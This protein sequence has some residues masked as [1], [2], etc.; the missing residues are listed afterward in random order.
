M[1]DGMLW[2]PREPL[3][4]ASGS[5]TRREMLA[6]A[7]IPVEVVR[8]EVDERALE[9]SLEGEVAS[10]EKVARTLAAA[11]AL[12][13]SALH[14]DRLVLAADQTLDCDGRSFHK[15][16]DLAEAAEQ[17]LRLAGRSHRL[18]AAFALAHRGEVVAEGVERANLAM[19]AFDRAFV[20]RY[21]A[22]AGPSILSSVGGYQ[23]EGLGA[24]LFER[25]EGDHFTILGL[26]LLPV[27]AAL[28]AQRCLAA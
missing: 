11:K 7:G 27:F 21:L 22:A 18:H 15:P 9:A 14:P 26:P 4:L 19:R 16:A 20:D 17:L 5:A 10:A 6:G 3:I 1:S 28:R 25:I 12:A 23:I 24:Q 13:V 8:P 2:L